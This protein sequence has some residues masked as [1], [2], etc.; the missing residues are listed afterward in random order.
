MIPDIRMD[1][2]AAI[3]GLVGGIGGLIS[4]LISVHQWWKVNKKI[5]MLTDASKAA[6]VLPAWYTE[7][8]MQ[9]YWL[10]GL[11]MRDG[12]TMAIKQITAISDDG[13]WMDVELA[14]A[15]EV[16]NLSNQW[17]PF[18]TAIA[19]DRLKASLQISTIVAA[20]ELQTS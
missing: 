9:D 6:E 20:V 19:H 4:V 17:G 14:E 1:Y 11:L 15:N 8:M 3:I 16:E 7:R 18:V 2:V 10:F 5:A 13:R 12:R